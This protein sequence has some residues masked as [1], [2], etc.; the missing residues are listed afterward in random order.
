VYLRKGPNT[1]NLS[2]T[3]GGRGGIRTIPCEVVPN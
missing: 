1:T 3:L 2:L